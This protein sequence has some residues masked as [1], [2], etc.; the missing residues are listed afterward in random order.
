LTAAPLPVANVLSI[1]GVDPSGGAGLLGDLKTFTALGTFGC[2]VV[3]ALTAQ[4]TRGVTAIERPSPAFV[5]TQLTTLFAD[6]PIA[7]AKT[8]MLGEAAVAEV[9]ADVLS[10]LIAEWPLPLVVDPVMVATSGDPLLTA[11]GVTTLCERLLPIATVVTPNLP[12]A[13]ALTGQPL[14]KK[15]EEMRDLA[16]AVRALLPDQPGRWVFLKGGH[17]PDGEPLCDIAFDG[18]SWLTFPATRRPFGMLHGTGCTLAAAIAALLGQ[19]ALT[20]PRGTVLT[21]AA[22]QPLF[23]TAHRYLQAAIAAA[24]RLSAGS[25]A[26]PLFHAVAQRQLPYSS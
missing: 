22:A 12:E 25:G 14:P 15:V 2:G 23:A 26:K 13:A 16:A 18:T 4:N 11:D 20:V 7:A 21:P 9:V 19:W 6:V 17:L 10:Q 8:G 3:T 1:A 5:R 24:T